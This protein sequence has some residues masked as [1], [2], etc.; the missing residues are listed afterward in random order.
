MGADGVK[1]LRSKYKDA[2]YRYLYYALKN[3]KIPD[4][5]YNRHFKWLKNV[6]IKYLDAKKQSEIV[7]ILDKVSSIINRK[8]QE[9]NL[10]DNLIKSRLRF[11]LF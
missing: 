1:I 9:V 10:L 7:E 8:R 2:N 11:H 3:A 5:G 4:T 6:E